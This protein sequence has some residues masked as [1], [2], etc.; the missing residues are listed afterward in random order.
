MPLCRSRWWYVYLTTDYTCPNRPLDVAV[1]IYEPSIVTAFENS[2]VVSQTP[3]LLENFEPT[4]S[5]QRV[6]SMKRALD[7]SSPSQARLKLQKCLLS[8]L[9]DSKVGVYSRFHE[10][11]IYWFGY[12]DPKTIRIADMYV[13]PI[14][15]VLFTD[16]PLASTAFWTRERQDI[17]SRKRYGR[18]TAASTAA[19]TFLHV[20]LKANHQSS[21]LG[22]LYHG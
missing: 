20:Y 18:R 22:I 8:G 21:S 7:R 16:A 3:D 19:G 14:I 2:P 9:S 13:H 12:D 15:Q 1:C 11:A 6:A 4:K 5:I 17:D 10:I